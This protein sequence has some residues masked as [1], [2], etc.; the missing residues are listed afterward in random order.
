MKSLERIKCLAEASADN[1]TQRKNG[2]LLLEPGKIPKAHHMLFQPLEDALISEYLIG[3]YRNP[4]PNEY[5]QFLK[6][7][8]GALLYMFQ[9]AAGRNRFAG[10]SLSIFGIPRTPP[11]GRPLDMEEPYDIRVEDLRRHPDTPASWLQVGRFSYMYEK[12]HMDAAIFL[13]CTTEK[14]VT[15]K[16]NTCDIIETWSGLDECL[17]DLMDRASQYKDAYKL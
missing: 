2:T 17:C 10:I 6:Y 5:I 3:A 15:C 11:F 4:I 12:S 9:Y 14:A 1:S 7:S 8:N 16:L 13:D